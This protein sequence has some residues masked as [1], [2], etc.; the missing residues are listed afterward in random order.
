MW[1]FLAVMAF[2]AGQVYLFRCLG[3]LEKLQEQQSIEEPQKEV[4]SIALSDWAAADSLTRI[5]E[6]F[7]GC[8]PNVEIMLLTG[9]DV[10][11]AVQNGRAAVGFL[12]DA[13]YVRPNSANMMVVTVKTLPRQQMIWKGNHRS[14]P[15]E[16]FVEYLWQQSMVE[17]PYNL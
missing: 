2:L 6:S 5:L 14:C 4:L 15:A 8:C 12:P 16:D 3:R 7:S 10:W 11:E 13:G 9:Q 17:N 1:I